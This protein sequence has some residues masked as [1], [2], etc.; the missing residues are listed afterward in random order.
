LLQEVRGA[1]GPI[2]GFNKEKSENAFLSDTN[3]KINWICNFGYKAE[4][5]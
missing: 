3:Y 2:S 4:G 5:N 1:C